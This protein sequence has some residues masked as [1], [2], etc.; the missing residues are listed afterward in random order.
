MKNTL[1]IVLSLFAFLCLSNNLSATVYCWE[2]S[3]GGNGHYYEF[4]YHNTDWFTARDTAA[5]ATHNG[6]NGHLVTITSA[7]ENDF[8]WNHMKLSATVDWRDRGNWI[9]AYQS[10]A[11]LNETDAEQGFAPSERWTWVTGETWTY[12]NWDT[13]GP[14]LYTRPS[15]GYDGIRTKDDYDYV[16]FVIH[17]SSTWRD[18]TPWK[19]T[20]L[21]DGYVIEYDNIPE[22]ATLGLLMFGA[23]WLL[24]RQRSIY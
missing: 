23:G 4:V 1:V 24:R 15:D 21:A 17:G 18:S 13:T 19:K 9:G 8:V 22:P 3:A 14:G 5:A 16:R 6:F 10:G 7:A 2:E 11:S 20:N 12:N